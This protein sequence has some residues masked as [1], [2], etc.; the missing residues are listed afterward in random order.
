M[1]VIEVPEPTA[2][3]FPEIVVLV[4]VEVVVLADALWL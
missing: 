3:V 2:A 4:D 1:V